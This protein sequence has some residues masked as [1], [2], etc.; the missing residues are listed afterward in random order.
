MR[1]LSSPLPLTYILPRH[2]SESCHCF[3]YFN[4]SQHTR[5]T[6]NFGALYCN[7]APPFINYS[8][9]PLYEKV[10]AVLAPPF[11][12]VPARGAARAVALLTVRRPPTLADT[13]SAEAARAGWRLPP[14][15]EFSAWRLLCVG[16]ILKLGG[17]SIGASP[18]AQR[19]QSKSSVTP[20]LPWNP[21]LSES[22]TPPAHGSGDAA[23]RWLPGSA[24][25]KSPSKSARGY[26][27]DFSSSTHVCARSKNLADVPT[28]CVK[29]VAVAAA[30]AA[31][32]AAAA[33]GEAA[34][35]T[36]DEGKAPLLC[37]ASPRPLSLS[38]L[39][40]VPVSRCIGEGLCV[41]VQ[42]EN[43][44]SASTRLKR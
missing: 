18:A 37:R 2:S 17:S 4:L 5:V 34:A 12:P 3:T 23:A 11:A 7:A 26:P 25:K 16:P 1:I 30:A 42:L 43:A 44:T 28:P 31:S 29:A 19:S 41:L 38:P 35:A 36:E 40:R 24:P 39:L 21:G 14:E 22:R 10:R 8:W 13:R 6:L 32:A 9:R 33:V 15:C 20:G 27:P